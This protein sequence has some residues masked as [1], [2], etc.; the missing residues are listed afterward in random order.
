MKALQNIDRIQ[1]SKEVVLL[2]VSLYESK[3]KAFYYNEL[4]QRDKVSF[5][6]KAKELNMIN[7]AKIFKLNLTKSRINLLAR[8]D[9]VAKNK[10]EQFF[11]NIKL[12]LDRLHNSPNNFELIVNEI[13]SLLKVLSKESYQIS[14]NSYEIKDKISGRPRRQNKRIDLDELINLFET[15]LRSK[16][17]E[18]TQ[19]ITNFYVDFINMEITTEYNDL[20]AIIILYSLLIKNFSVFHYVSFFKH[21]NN[22]Y[23]K[24]EQALIQATYY[25]SEGFSQTEMLSR[26]LMEMLIEIYKE[27]DSIAHEYRFEKDLNKS[28][29]IENSI[30]KMEEIFAKEDIRKR[31]PNVSDA[32]INRTLKRLKDDNIITPLGKGRSS[33][34]QRIVKG[35]ETKKIKQLSFFGDEI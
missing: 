26:I 27:I 7:I 3:G 18:L 31:H 19:L 32:T 10:D 21:F 24:W 17:Y 20:I 15:E 23:Q 1:I 5:E 6:R 12:A 11:N 33:K 30:L 16:N 2:L 14:F 8:K 35:H 13:E 34:W 28:D 9:I 4:F 25:W 22:Y 29:S